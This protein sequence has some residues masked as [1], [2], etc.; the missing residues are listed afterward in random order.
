M[1]TIT[2]LEERVEK[3]EHLLDIYQEMWTGLYRA[4]CMVREV[5]KKNIPKTKTDTVAGVKKYTER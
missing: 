3:M 4:I 1:T 2:E 5:S